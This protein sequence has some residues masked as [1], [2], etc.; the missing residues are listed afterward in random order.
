MEPA[1]QLLCEPCC[2]AQSRIVSAAPDLTML[3]WPCLVQ[4]EMSMW[5]GIW[6]M[7]IC[8]LEKGY[9][10]SVFSPLLTMALLLFVSGIPIQEKQAKKRWGDDPAYQRY[11]RHSNVLVPLPLK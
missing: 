5:W 4:G 10:L 2:A 9:W 7:S 6:L 8:I 1:S 11:L 3:S